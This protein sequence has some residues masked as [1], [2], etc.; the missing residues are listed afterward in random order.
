MPLRAKIVRWLWECW[1]MRLRRFFDSFTPTDYGMLGE[2]R[3]P[4]A[5]YVCTSRPWWHMCCNGDSGGRR[6]DLCSKL[7]YYWR[8]H[9]ELAYIA[10]MPD[11]EIDTSDIPEV[12]DWTGAKRGLFTK[13]RR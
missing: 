10:A 5:K 13:R 12:K 1:H 6:T 2:M 11:R 7:E 4:Y 8:Y 9:D 3:L